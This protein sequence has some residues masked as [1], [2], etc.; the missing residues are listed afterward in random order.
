MTTET[1]PYAVKIILY[2]PL[3]LWMAVIFYLSS[4]TGSGAV[5]E[6]PK[7]MFLERKGAH[8]FEYAVLTLLFLRIFVFCIPKNRIRAFWLSAFLAVIYAVS[9]ETHQLF[10]FGRTGKATDVL[11]DSVGVGLALIGVWF[12]LKQRWLFVDTFFPK[13]TSKSRLRHLPRKKKKPT[14]KV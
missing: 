7:I 6:M 3:L 9:D 1:S 12:L 13:S 14:I 11:I 2:A 10:V 4:M 5:Y 8:I